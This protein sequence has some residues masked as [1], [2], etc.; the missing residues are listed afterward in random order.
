MKFKAIALTIAALTSFIFTSCEKGPTGPEA[1]MAGIGG[2]EN[3]TG[4]IV[5]TGGPGIMPGPG[6]MTAQEYVASRT[7]GRMQVRQ[8]G[9][10]KMTS[11][12]RM[13][14]KL[15]HARVTIHVNPDGTEELKKREVTGRVVDMGDPCLMKE[16]S[17]IRDKSEALKY[18][19]GVLVHRPEHYQQVAEEDLAKLMAAR[20]KAGLNK[21]P[22]P[23]AP[24]Q[25]TRR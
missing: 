11:P 3:P 7:G 10:Q 9:V 19:N 5:S 14:S 2:S 24:N 1:G 20:E 25:L 4:E 18:H 16:G 21:R 15:A 6:V 12:E 23:P 13:D 22:G 8:T 17:V